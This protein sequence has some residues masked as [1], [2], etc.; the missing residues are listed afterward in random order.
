[1]LFAI[2][3]FSIIVDVWF[4]LKTSEGSSVIC[5]KFSLFKSSL[6][7]HSDYIDFRPFCSV[8]SENSLIISVSYN[9][10]AYVSLHKDGLLGIGIIFGTLQTASLSD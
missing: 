10:F 5:S 2:I 6:F 3:A 1:M 4:P 8:S 7:L 9:F